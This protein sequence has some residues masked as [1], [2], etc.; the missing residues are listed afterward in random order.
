MSSF[1]PHLLGIDGLSREDIELIVQTAEGLSEV[2]GRSVKKVPLMRGRTVINLFFEPSTRTRTSFEVAAKRLSADVIN[3]SAHQSSVKKG[4]SLKDT[5]LTL[6]AMHPDVVV[7]RHASSGT[8]AFVAEVLGDGVSVINAGDG[9]NEHPTQAL[10][11]ALTIKQHFGKLSGL[12]IA[13][14]GDILRG[15]V[16]RSNIFLHSLLGNEIRLVA[17]PTLVPRGFESLG[18]SVH[19]DLAEGIEGADIVMSLRVKQEYLA[20]TFLPSI[21]E[22]ARKFCLTTEAL[23]RYAPNSVLLAPGPFIR[24]V[25][26]ESTLVD[27]PRSKVFEQVSNGIPVRMATIMLLAQYQA[28]RQESHGQP[29]D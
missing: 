4:E 27:G 6:R 24:G 22:Y 15:R 5:V 11:D 2:S 26:L 13:L 18:A 3:F 10:L 29:A 25:E 16:A 20:G 28:K 17:P 1:G 14:V 23:E 19:Y 7:V 8:C 12:K 9:L 21:E